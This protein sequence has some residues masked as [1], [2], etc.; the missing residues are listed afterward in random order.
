LHLPSAPSAAFVAAAL[1]DGSTG[2][3]LRL[4]HRPAIL[5]P[6][7]ILVHP[8]SAI[9]THIAVE[10]IVDHDMA[11]MDVFHRLRQYYAGDAGTLSPPSSS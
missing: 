4:H 6:S 7:Y 10:G 5:V 9:D 1:I 3:A 2:E 8:Q 11:P